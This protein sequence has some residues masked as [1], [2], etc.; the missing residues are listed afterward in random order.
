MSAVTPF[1]FRHTFSAPRTQVF[2]LYAEPEH[3]RASLGG[4]G[5]E[6]LKCAMTF[7]VGGT[8]HYGTKGPGPGE[9][10]GFQR[11]LAIAAGERIE[12]LQ[13]FSAAE[14][15]IAPHP[16]APT[17]PLVTHSTT[18]FE[19]T[20][21]GHTLVTVTWVPHE[22]DAAALAT[23]DAAREGMGHGFGALYTK[24]DAYLAT[25]AS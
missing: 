14:G 11:Y 22:A 2:A 17:W 5:V 21:E 23:F 6:V 13:S 9:T 25:L 15:G 4:D 7:E 20:A 10:W 3:V 18:T 24:L 19:D 16:M 8:H 1:V 12:L